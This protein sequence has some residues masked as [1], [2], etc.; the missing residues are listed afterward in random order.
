MELLIAEWI[1][2]C[3]LSDSNFNKCMSQ[4]VTE[5][6]HRL[7]NGSKELGI[8]PMEPFSVEQ[9]DLKQ[10]KPIGQIY[11]NVK[12]FGFTNAVMYDGK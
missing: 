6:L 4:R 12:I 1:S 9:I 8:L 5:T 11:K 3:S 10:F 7:G 2:K